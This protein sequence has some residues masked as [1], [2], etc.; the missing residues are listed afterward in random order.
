[1]GASIFLYT[2]AQADK[3]LTIKYTHLYTL[4]TAPPAPCMFTA[5]YSRNY[6]QRQHSEIFGGYYPRHISV[7]LCI[8][9]H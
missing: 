6:R 7:D 5:K 1:M 9:Q 8:V 2:I 4:L 3:R